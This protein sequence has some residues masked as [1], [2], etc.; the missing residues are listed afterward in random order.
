MKKKT[1]LK[2]FPDTSMV[3]KLP[4][5]VEVTKTFGNPYRGSGSGRIEESMSHAS[6]LK[7]GA[8]VLIIASAV[9]ILIRQ[10]LSASSNHTAISALAADVSMLEQQ[11]D[12]GPRILWQHLPTQIQN[13]CIE[14]RK[15]I[16]RENGLSNSSFTELLELQFPELE[17]L[18]DKRTGNFRD[19]RLSNSSWTIIADGSLRAR[20][21]HDDGSSK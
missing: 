10:V 8:V 6:P 4:D 21:R 20:I 9:F 14:E 13:L 15:A 16:K 7:Y 12:H 3:I 1:S 2:E 5:T 17:W 18:E 11:I 19:M